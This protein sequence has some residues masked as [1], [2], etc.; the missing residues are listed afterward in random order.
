MV[1]YG[2]SIRNSLGG[3]M[4]VK[5][6]REELPSL[7]EGHRDSTAQESDIFEH[8]VIISLQIFTLYLACVSQV[9]CNDTPY[10][11]TF[12][13]ARLGFRPLRPTR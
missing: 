13:V 2:Y 4:L 8:L 9:L 3:Q 6:S 5:P 7:F 11:L 12:D 10:T 1:G